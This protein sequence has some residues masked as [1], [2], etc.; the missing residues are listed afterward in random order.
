MSWKPEIEEIRQRKAFATAMGGAEA[1]DKARAAGK[2]NA[3]QRIDLLL[4]KDSFREIGGL[5]GTAQYDADGTLI[6]VEP[7]T[8]IIGTGRIEGRKVV[9][10]ADDSS[11]RGGSSDSTIAEKWIYAERMAL[12]MGLPLIRL[13]DSAG[14]SIRLLE[15][16]QSTRLPGYGTWEAAGMLGQIPVVGVALGACAGLGAIKVAGSHFSVMVKAASQVFAA[17]PFI[18]KE[19]LGIDTDKEALGGAAIHARGSGVV[20]NEAGTEADALSQARQFL[21]YLPSNV[22]DLPPVTD[23][24]DSP[25]RRE[26]KLLSAIPREPRRA[27]DIRR[28]IALVFDQGS[29]FELGRYSGRSSVTGLARLGGFPVGILANDPAHAGGA[30]TR[31]SAQKIESFVDFCD[32]FHLPIVSLVDQPGIM[33]GP[34]AEK[35]GTIRS[36]LRALAAIEQSTT[37]WCTIILRRAFGVAGAAHGR[38]GGINLRYGWPSAKWGSLPLEGGIAAAYRRQI[39]AAPDPDAMKR[40]LHDKYAGFTSP[41]R[42]AER[43]GVNDII[44]PRETRPLLCDWIETAWSQLPRMLGPSR[45]T[46]RK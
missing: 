8:A 2:L 46:M 21:S 23:C 11:I 22:H 12:E 35:S 1:L 41:F 26:E 6:H 30:M 25:D 15:R 44:D 16:N 42:T 40:D 20:D 33:I 27:Y 29:F 4:D 32:T 38:L 31:S 17:G 14:G 5:T 10:S 24:V 39:E 34:D 28:I 37:P 13:V 3:R 18:V 9:V 7:A 36:A 45:R 43:F 19:G